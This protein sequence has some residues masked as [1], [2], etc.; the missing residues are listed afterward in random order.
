MIW[1]VQYKF[2]P[3]AILLVLASDVYKAEDYIRDYD[4]YL[5]MVSGNN[6]GDGDD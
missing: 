4:E 1:G 5:E 2:T 3:D 6:A